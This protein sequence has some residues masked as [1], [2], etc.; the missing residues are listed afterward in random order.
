M[1]YHFY[2]AVGVIIHG[3]VTPNLVVQ[4]RLD[5]QHCSQPPFSKTVRVPTDHRVNAPFRFQG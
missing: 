5:D 2:D 4:H 1:S 3:D